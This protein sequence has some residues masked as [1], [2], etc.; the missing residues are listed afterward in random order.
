MKFGKND[1]KLI[2]LADLFKEL[3]DPK[4]N[5]NTVKEMFDHA[6]CKKIIAYLAT[7]KKTKICLDSEYKYH[8]TTIGELEERVWQMELKMRSLF[9]LEKKVFNLTKNSQEATDGGTGQAQRW[10]HSTS[11][12]LET[13]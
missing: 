8:E 7:P 10:G 4:N 3:L 2:D 12:D 11:T 1:K 9:V 13:W 5:I 6:S